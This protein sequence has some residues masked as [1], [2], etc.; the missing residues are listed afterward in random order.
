MSSLSQESSPHNVPVDDIPAIDLSPS[1]AP[2]GRTKDGRWPANTF[3]VPPKN[4][5]L[6]EVPPL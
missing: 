1:S 4:V 2:E 6:P 3:A 5:R